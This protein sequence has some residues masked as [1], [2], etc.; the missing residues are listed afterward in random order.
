[1]SY[2]IYLR[3]SRK[4][5]EAELHGEGETLARHEKI[6]TELACKMKLDVSKIYREVVSGETIAARPL[7]QQLL[8]E[9]LEG[10]WDGVLVME[11]ERL[12]RGDTMDQ[13]QVA[14]SFKLNGTKIIT[15]VKTYDPNNEFDEEYFEFGLF[16]SRREYKTIKRRLVRGRVSAV[17]EGKF[18]SSQAP[19]GYQ[20]VKIKNDKGYTL[21][22]VEDEAKVVQQVFDYYTNGEINEIGKYIRLGLPSIAQRLDSMHIKPKN[23]EY[24]SKATLRNML[25]NPLYMGKIRYGY[26]NEQKIYSNGVM[27]KK[28][29]RNNDYLLCDALHAPIIKEEQFELAQKLLHKNRKC[30]VI[31]TDLR[32]PLTGIVYCKKC[33][34]LMT[35]LAENSRNQYATIK[36]PNR[37]CDNISA[38]LYL[39]ERE[40]INHLQLWLQDYR[41]KWGKN[42]TS[43]SIETNQKIDLLS[44]A[45]KQSSNQLETLNSQYNKTFDLLE[46]GIYSTEIFMQRNYAIKTQ[47]EE[48]ELNISNLTKQLNDENKRLNARTLIIPRIESMIDVYFELDVNEKN[49]FL[50]SIIDRVDYIKTA[51]NTRTQRENI[52]FVLYVYPSMD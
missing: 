40:L 46:Q 23:S 44:V 38:P 25:T 1:M 30:T 29:T 10:K 42:E 27:K 4:D 8:S 26:D 52:N 48:T 47:I 50:K 28:R 51:R 18:V 36:C 6:L 14:K 33:G 13:G 31:S 7:M 16:M 22:I 43:E 24:W 2:C 17:K 45:I 12:A 15:P 49:D 21:E 20:K 35:R 34:S 19:Y 5:I 11:V 9:V 32:N 37:Y 3:K 39:V 41:F